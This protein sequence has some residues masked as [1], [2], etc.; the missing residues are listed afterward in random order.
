MQSVRK[1]ALDAL[2][3]ILRGGTKPREALEGISE[4]LSKKDRA[5]LMET[6]YGVL[7]L[8]DRLDWIINHFLKK[9]SGVKGPTRDNLRLGI[10]QI[11]HMRVPDWAAVDEAVKLERRNPSLVNA[12]LRNAIRD[13]GDIKG[14]LEAMRDDALGDSTQLADKALNVSV[15]TSHPVWLVRR[16]IK[17]FGVKETLALAEANNRIPPLTLRVNT[18]KATRDEILNELKETGIE[19][20]PTELSPQGISL[21]GTVPIGEI[22]AFMGKVYIQDEAA[23][24]VSQMLEPKP[25][26]RVLDAC[27]APGGKTTHIA[28]LMGDTG[29]VVAVDSDERRI[30]TMKE[31]IVMTGLSNIKVVLGDITSLRGLGLFDRVLVDAPCSATGVIR[32]NPDVKYRYRAGDLFKF[33]ERQLTILRSAAGFLK[34]EGLLVYCTCSTE[35]EEGEQVMQE[36]LKTSGDFYNINDVPLGEDFMRTYPHRN[37]MDGFFAARLN[38]CA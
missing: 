27:A 11:F 5:F 34:P 30:E 7:R 18:M 17:R 16:W 8:R 19:A 12:I 35:P 6:T 10:Y 24:L 21:K 28:D 2:K 13:K 9:P 4:G 33:K 23:Q 31:N 15:L 29:E 14:E 37:N 22:A 3:D 38:R 25:G 20:G 1:L 26:E 36:F 32:R